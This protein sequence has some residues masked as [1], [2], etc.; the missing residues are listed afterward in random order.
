[1]FGGGERT[2]IS[3]A[4]QDQRILEGVPIVAM[5]GFCGCMLLAD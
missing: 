3:E 2:E 1:M 5:A 4:G